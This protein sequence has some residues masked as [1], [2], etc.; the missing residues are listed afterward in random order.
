MS[1]TREVEKVDLDVSIVP[2]TELVF[3]TNFTQVK[4]E[5]SKK[6]KKYKGLKVSDSNF[7]HCKLVQKQCVSTRNLLENRRREVMKAYIEAPKNNLQVMFNELQDIIA[8]VEKNIK[9]QMDVYEQERIEDLTIILNGYIKDFQKEY[10][11]NENYADRVELKKKYFNKTAKEKETIED[12]RQQFEE[13]AKDQ[14]AYENDVRLIKQ[15]IG[16]NG[17]I[18]PDTYTHMLEHKSVSEIIMQINEEKDRL[19]SLMEEKEDV[20]SIG[21]PV[22]ESTFLEAVSKEPKKEFEGL[23]LSTEFMSI[24]RDLSELEE[25]DFSGNKKSMVIKLEYPEE[26]GV[27]IKAFFESYKQIKVSK[28]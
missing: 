11:L 20:K 28:G 3:D 19:A 14:R 1:K 25:E 18:N 10:C 26:M 5:L 23:E 13:A 9:Q 2:K 27:L 24:A 6:L 12:I 16:D 4:K 7:E 8:D 22:E 15:T 17:L 21:V